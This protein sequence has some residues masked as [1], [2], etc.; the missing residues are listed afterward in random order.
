VADT[1]MR[2]NDRDFLIA[3]VMPSN[4]GLPDFAQVWTPIGLTDEEKAVRGEHHSIVIARLK[5]GANIKSAQA[6]MNTISNRLEQLYPADDKG[7]GAVVVPLHDDLVS[8][9]RPALLVLLGAVAFV[10]LIACVNVANLALAKA[11]SRQKEIA[12]RTALGASSSRVLRQILTESVLLALTG[13]LLGLAWA[14]LGV[15]LIMAFLG[16]QLPKFLGVRPD[17][18]VLFFTAAISIFTGILAGVLP[19]L[20]LSRNNVTQTLKQGLG[21]TDADTSGQTTRR[22][23]VVVEVA[24]SLLLLMG[25]GLMIRSLQRLYRVDAG[26]D[27]HGV[28]TMT[29]AIPE[30]K[31]TAAKQQADFF[32]QVLL[33]ERSLPGV[34]SA[35]V[36]DDI[37]LNQG[38]SVQP[39]QID[40]QPIVA[41][42]EQPEVDTRLISPGYMSAMRTPVL[43]GRDF[44][45]S[46]VEGRPAV[47]LISQSISR[48][49]WPGQ[50]PIGKRL[51]MTFT[52][53]V[54]REVIGVVGDV[55]L[56]GLDQQRP[57]EAIYLP[58]AQMTDTS[59]GGWRAFPM[60]LVVRTETNPAGAISAVQNA[61]RQVDPTVVLRDVL[62]M[63]DVVETSLSQRR[64]NTLLLGSFAGLALL[65]AVVGIYGV[66]SYSVRRRVR[67]IGIRVALGAR[68]GDVLRMVVLEG[69]KPTLLGVG[70]GIIAALGLGR[71]VSSLI[72]GVRPSDPLTLVL[73]ALLLS[74]V[75]FLASLIPAYRATKVDPMV[76]LRYE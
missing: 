29:A 47:A 62:T 67:E 68:L 35:G 65:L 74:F 48:R 38:G 46:D 51:T 66:L 8:D 49:F 45:D 13:G 27:P 33:R 52:P 56:D 59:P 63:D 10:L 21:R 5:P 75:A 50:D 70:I 42:S 31:F 36:V 32:A 64:L 57:E 18:E 43:R 72:Y 34:V 73:V 28:V 44:S 53:G 26:F 6:E 20:R 55:K 69:M 61:I 37:P 4:F 19:A 76:A 14:N 54:V 7:W 40:G 30:S 24:L 39:V 1:H 11:F 41:M 22:A 58:L 60:T 16:D 17:A 2:L 23:L 15:R 71:T 12:I 9:V 3:G 25:A